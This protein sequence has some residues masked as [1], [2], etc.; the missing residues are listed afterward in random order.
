MLYK[1]MYERTHDGSVVNDVNVNKNSFYARVTEDVLNISAI[2]FDFWPA[3]EEDLR[4]R[5]VRQRQAIIL[6]LLLCLHVSIIRSPFLFK[7]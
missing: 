7:I 2:S 6:S 5:R 1:R 3:T 4:I